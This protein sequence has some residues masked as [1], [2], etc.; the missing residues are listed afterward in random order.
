VVAGIRR[1]HLLPLARKHAADAEM[2]RGILGES[3][4][5]VCDRAVL[6]FGMAGAF[7]RSELVELILADVESVPEGCGC[8]SAAARSTRNVPAPPPPSPMDVGCGPK[9]PDHLAPAPTGAGRCSGGYWRDRVLAGP[10]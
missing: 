5:G 3:L 9:S 4:H 2:L 10:G 1:R 8:A 7:R 6:A